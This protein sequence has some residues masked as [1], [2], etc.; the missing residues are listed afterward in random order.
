MTDI[1][2][3]QVPPV[4][5]F[6]CYL[7]YVML[8]SN[9]RPKS[10]TPDSAH[11]NWLSSHLDAFVSG[12]QQFQALCC[13]DDF[14]PRIEKGHPKVT[15]L[16]QV[17]F[18]PSLQLGAG[19][20]IPAWGAVRQQI[21]SLTRD[22]PPLE[23]DAPPHAQSWRRTSVGTPGS[24]CD[25]HAGPACLGTGTEMPSQM[26]TPAVAPRDSWFPQFCHDDSISSS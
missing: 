2:L 1:G 26:Q 25:F 8:N 6:E 14:I 23:A 13:R 4:S 10:G 18:P 20:L 15:W 19:I 9:A 3:S 12:L 22:V 24:Q 17:G 16:R 5:V 21:A 7:A 11:G